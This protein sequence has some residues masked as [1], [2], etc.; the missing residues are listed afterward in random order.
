MRIRLLGDQSSRTTS[1][2]CKPTDAALN[3][4]SVPLIALI[5]ALSD[6]F[7]FREVT[8]RIEPSGRCNGVKDLVAGEIRE[9]DDPEVVVTEITHYGRSLV[10]GAAYRLTAL[11]VI[12]VRDGEIVRY[13][14]YMNP[15]ALARL[16]GRT[17]ELAAALAS[18]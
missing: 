18:T 3:A 7:F 4:R 16:L 5:D 2:R 13:D 15:V 17:D 11:G 14:D 8:A 9:T 12:R 10:T 6:R 1:A